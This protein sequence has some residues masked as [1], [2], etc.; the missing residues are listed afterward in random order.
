MGILP[1]QFKKGEGAVELG[2]KGLETFTLN[3]TEA[4]LAIG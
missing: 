4:T 1:L 3:F 2:L